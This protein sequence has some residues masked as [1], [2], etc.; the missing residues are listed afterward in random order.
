MSF[1]QR[2]TTFR[3]DKPIWA[4]SVDI[5]K[6]RSARIR[7]ESVSLNPENKSVV[8]AGT[9]IARYFDTV[10]G[11]DDFRLLP[12]V[13]LVADLIDGVDTSFFV[14]NDYSQVLLPGDILN[15]VEPHTSF[16]VAAGAG[17]LST[18]TVDGRA[19]DYTTTQVAVA[20]VAAELAVFYNDAPYV[21][22]KYYFAAD[23]SGNLHI[24]SRDGV[25]QYTG[26]TTAGAA[27][28]APGAIATV[29]V[30]TPV[31]TVSQIS[32]VDGSVV[33]TAAAGVGLDLP[34]G[35]HLGVVSIKEVYGLLDVSL[36]FTA[37]KVNADVGL[38]HE[39][40]VYKGSLPYYDDTIKGD[41]P[42]LEV[43]FK[44]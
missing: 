16:L 10:A 30:P 42:E 21:S 29:V 36:D 43:Q 25:S 5:S 18:I 15:I 28:A 44:F 9:F 1:F 40:K 35:T 38:G 13:E 24:F 32:T 4:T 39:G 14:K 31:G 6:A 27:Y 12:R 37:F 22:D 41:L 2:Q 17:N 11:Q 8:A 33:L 3:Q 7:R 19:V 23:T 26:D 20:D 34:A